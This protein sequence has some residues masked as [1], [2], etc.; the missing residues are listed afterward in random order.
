MPE[1]ITLHP[2]LGAAGRSGLQTNQSAADCAYARCISR[3]G[4]HLGDLGDVTSPVQGAVL[5][6]V[7]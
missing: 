3:R 5:W 2:N 6:I 4:I 1:S 7:R